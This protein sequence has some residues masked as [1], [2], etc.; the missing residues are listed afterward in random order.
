[1]Y[2]RKALLA[3]Y[4]LELGLKTS[5]GKPEILFTRFCGLRGCL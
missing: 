1:S 3:L 4:D 5:L 2:F